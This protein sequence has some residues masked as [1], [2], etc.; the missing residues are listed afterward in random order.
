MQLSEGR[1]ESSKH[2]KFSGSYEISH[3]GAWPALP[4]VSQPPTTVRLP[5]GQLLFLQASSA[6]IANYL[7]PLAY[8]VLS[9]RQVLLR[10]AGQH[11]CSSFVKLHAPSCTLHNR[12]DVCDQEGQ[13]GTSYQSSRYQASIYITV[14]KDRIGRREIKLIAALIA[15][16]TPPPPPRKVSGS[17]RPS[18]FSGTRISGCII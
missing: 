15:H 5:L 8:Q 17:I 7:A 9:E 11:L 4:S 18:Y 14:F 2:Y 16:S 12:N 1:A 6:R 3:T 10:K 13:S